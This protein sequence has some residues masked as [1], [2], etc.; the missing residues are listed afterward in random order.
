MDLMNRV[1]GIFTG[2]RSFT[3][4]SREASAEVGARIRHEDEDSCLIEVTCLGRDL[5]ALLYELRPGK[6]LLTVLS[7]VVFPPGGLPRR[8]RAMLGELNENREGFTFATS[9][10]DERARFVV[11]AELRGGAVTAEALSEA[12]VDLCPRIVALDDFMAREGYVR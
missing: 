5:L 8:V 9:E 2:R 12:L 3:E 4:L 10:T 6:V 11:R 7:G 1:L